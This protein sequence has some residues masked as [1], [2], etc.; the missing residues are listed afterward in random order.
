MSGVKTIE[1]QARWGAKLS[2]VCYFVLIVGVLV[3]ATILGLLMF[4]LGVDYENPSFPVGLLAVPVNESII[5]GVTLLFAKHR[6]VSLNELG[7]KRVSLQTLLIV[8]VLAF[9]LYALGLGISIGEEIVFG[10]DPTGELFAE[11]L[12]PK[13]SFQLVVTVALHLLLVGPCEELAFRGFIQKGFENSFGK[14]KGLVVASIL[15]GLVHG[16]N[17]LYAIVPLIAAG[18]F[19]GYLWLWTG[20]N[21][22]A[23]ALTHGIN[24]SISIAIAY[25][26]TA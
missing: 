22:T 15:F 7:L 4:G 3:G 13:D 14:L 18:L 11:F 20:G 25:F 17:T 1:G 9:F 8:S 19:L 6:G 10:P 12:I 16:L 23:S 21:T 5:L 24:N 2:L 26:L